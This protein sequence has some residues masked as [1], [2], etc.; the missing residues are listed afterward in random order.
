VDRGTA[1]RARRTLHVAHCTLHDVAVTIAAFLTCVPIAHAQPP[2]PTERVTFNE[3][4]QR[5]IER[6][7]SSAIAAAGIL[8][9]DALLAQARSAARLQVNGNV[10]TTTLNTGIEF[11][12]TTVTPRNSVT[13][14]L[15]VRMPIYAPAR[16]AFQLQAADQKRI[17]EVSAEETKRQT[18]LATADAYLAII[19]RRQV[20]EANVRALE[21]A[22]AHF[23]LASELEQGGTGSR[24]NQLRAQQE[25]TIDI[26][27]VEAAQLE[28]YRAQEALGVLLAAD[29]P[30]DAIDEPTFNTP[31]NLDAAADLNALL[32]NRRDLRLF[33]TRIEAADR[34]LRDSSKDRLPLLEGIFQPQSTYPSQFFVTANSWRLLF[35][36]SIPL[37]DS[38]LRTGQR[39]ERQAALDTSRATLT[40]GTTAARS[41]V[42]AAQQAV[43]SA[44]RARES[45]RAAAQ[46]AQQV[47]EIV[48]VSFRAGAATNIEVIDAE[49]RA[50]DADNAVAVADHTLRRAQL[51]LLTALGQFP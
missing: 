13:A 46:Q 3:A 11:E 38:G 22:K 47:V 25:Y 12:G 29:G 14:T 44:G 2:H 39:I 20:V 37:F 27:L 34:V 4:V 15:D 18:A 40:G 31:A 33:S 28:L 45:F 51:D 41:E 9:A 35:Q 48:N 7:P 8:R 42:R 26:G 50:R 30:V 19:A 21:T 16:W 17:A 49:R 5:A 1:H 10:T 43:L 24:L 36:A 32:V 6:N 23:D